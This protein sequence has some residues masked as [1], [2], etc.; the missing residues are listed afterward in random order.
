MNLKLGLILLL[1]L[2]FYTV[3][4]VNGVAPED[5]IVRLLESYTTSAR[6]QKVYLHL[7]KNGYKAG[8]TIWFKSYLFDG[9]SHSLDTTTSNL[10]VELI[11]SDGKAMEMRILM[12]EEGIANGDILLRSNMPDGNYLIRAYTDWM[13]N[14]D[15]KYY[16]TQHL[17]ITNQSYANMIPRMD[18]WRNRLFN[19]R[20]DRLAGNIDVAFFPEGGN[21][22]AGTVNRV[23]FKVADKLGNGLEAEAEIVDG[24]GEVVANANTGI[25]GIGVFDITPQTG[26]AYKARISV[27]GVRHVTYDLP[28]VMTEGYSLRVDDFD[29]HLVISVLA[30]GIAGTPVHSDDFILIGH[31]RG[32]PYYGQSVNTSEGR[33]ELQVEKD[34]FPSGISHFT[35][36]TGDLVPVA[37]RLVFIDHGD[38]FSFTPFLDVYEADDRELMNIQIEVTDHKGNPVAGN[39]S[40][41]AVS[42][43]NDRKGQK[44]IISYLLLESE[45]KDMIYDPYRYLN[46]EADPEI[47]AD[48]LLLTY[49][50]RRF[51]WDEV[52]SGEP[53]DFR[54]TSRRGLAIQGRLID[55]ARNEPL[56]NHP[57]QLVVRSGHD[58][59]FTTQTAGNGFF[60]FTGLVYEGLIEID[61]SSRRLATGHPPVFDLNIK[62]GRGYTYEPGIFTGKRNV[63]VRGDNW[64]RESGVSSTPYSSS[65]DRNVNPQIYGV[66]DQTIYID[67]E[68]TTERNLYDVLRNKASGISFIGGQI[69][70]RGPVSL[71]QS[72]EPRFMLDGMFIDKNHF[73]GLYPME[74]ERVEIFKGPK[75]AIFGVRGGAGVILAYTRRAGYSG[76][77]DVM[78]L[79]IMGYHS[80]NEFYSD[81]MSRFGLVSES[82]MEGKT[83][84][85]DP[86]LVSKE[87]GKINVSF[88]IGKGIKRLRFTIEGTGLNG[89][90]GFGEIVVDIDGP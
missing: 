13:R 59:V 68:S 27:N 37:E 83:I 88:P 17:N 44:D 25:S 53:L 14:F 57:V 38:R 1:V 74:I 86:N 77:E 45:I 69:T 46:S 47:S 40:V 19:R 23:A 43:N 36:F 66:P 89:G 78:Q 3:P 82:D 16:F 49:G 51:D 63:V 33:V 71:T 5:D 55:P 50:W 32:I 65:I 54:F 29:D 4:E 58:D 48:K 34:L 31:T 35:V 28:E 85:W 42:G 70:V 90:V 6:P 64:E 81:R 24:S 26:S 73:L 10:Y 67:Y 80:P 75:A 11:D 76:F 41:S 21:I 8:E 9:T 56:R 72:S 2:F 18:V 20:L 39:F 61:L 87:D 22:L 60:S 52:L 15:E 79:A 12:V 30:V 84:H 7:D 62:G